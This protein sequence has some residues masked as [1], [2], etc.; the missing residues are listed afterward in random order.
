MVN[1][2][3]DVT[4]VTCPAFA[5]GSQDDQLLAHALQELGYTTRVAVWSDPTVDWRASRVAVVRSTWDY[6]YHVEQ[7]FQWLANVSSQTQLINRVATLR[8]NSDKRYLLELLRGGVACIPSAIVSATDDVTQIALSRSWQD[9]I[10]KPLIAA[11]ARGVKRFQGDNIREANGYVGS[12]GTSDVLV[13]PYLAAVETARERSLV[14]IDRLFSHA[15]TKPA[16]STGAGGP[17]DLAL[18]EPSDAEM[19]LAQK[20]LLQVNEPLAYARVDLVPTNTGPLLMELE[21][22]EPDLSLRLAPQAVHRLALAVGA[23]LPS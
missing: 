22:I 5:Q 8:W 6:H 21:L 16:F 13:Q 18:H 1:V 17:I 15:V 23:A 4:I 10:V 20:A 19:A 3:V 7:W 9:I 2:L 14:F 11:S 12:L